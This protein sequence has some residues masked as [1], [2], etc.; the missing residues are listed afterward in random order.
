MQIPVGLGSDQLFVFLGV[1][2]R[3]LARFAFRQGVRTL[4]DEHLHDLGGRGESC[5]EHQRSPAVVVSGFDFG[6]VVDELLYNVQIIA[7]CGSV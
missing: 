3:F 5:G 4:V 7:S 2:D 6:L 1:V